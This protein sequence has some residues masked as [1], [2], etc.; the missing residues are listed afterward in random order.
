MPYTKVGANKISDHN[1]TSPLKNDLKACQQCHTETQQW[2]KDQVVAIQDRTV[3]LMNRSGYATAVTA[4]LFETAHKAQEQ[5][6]KID[7]ALYN[8][9]KDLY[10]E[11]LYR[12]IFIG[13]ENSVGFHNPTEAGRIMGDSVA[14]A[15]R[16]E[17]L[18]RQALT[19]AGVE[20]PAD[21]NLEIAKYVNERG[22]KKLNFRPEFEFKDP[23]GIQEMLTPAKSMGLTA[24]APAKPAAKAK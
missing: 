19:K 9:A 3:S 17:A 4:K 2:L 23:F 18:L 15:M 24:A 14:L 20:L 21:I 1:V 6:K 7:E 11:A 8:Q 10:L 22:V 16:S 12:V 13:A 5:G